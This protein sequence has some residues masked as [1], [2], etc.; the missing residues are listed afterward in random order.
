MNVRYLFSIGFHKVVAVC[1]LLLVVLYGCVQEPD[2]FL[3]KWER[4]DDKSAGSII[5]VEKIGDEYE[6]KLLK[7]SGDLADM[8]FVEGDIKWR[9]IDPK[10]ESHYEGS[11][12]LKGVDTKGAVRYK[13]YEEV[14][15]E[16]KNDDILLVSAY[17]EGEEEG[18]RQK[19][20][21]LSW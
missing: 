20:K 15:F 18:T 11:D 19:W 7:V 8:G 21:K 2:R 17:A 5:K 10:D 9:H 16:L 12:L 1:L 13:R 3:G 14:Y 6:G 4:Y